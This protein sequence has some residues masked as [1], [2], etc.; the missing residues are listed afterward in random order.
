MGIIGLWRKALIIVFNDMAWAYS[1][2]S[3]VLLIYINTSMDKNDT[4]ILL[5]SIQ[6]FLEI[7]SL[8][9]VID[10]EKK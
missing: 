2:Q 4:I 6:Q 9:V 8:C 7:V 1:T 3:T 10:Q 5:L